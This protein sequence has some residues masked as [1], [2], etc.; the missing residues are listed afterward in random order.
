MRKHNSIAI[1]FLTIPTTFIGTIIVSYS[2]IGNWQEL[3]VIISNE[4]YFGRGALTALVGLVLSVFVWRRGAS[5]TAQQK[6]V[7]F[8]TSLLLCLVNWGLLFMLPS[9]FAAFCAGLWLRKC[10][11]P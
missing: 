11:Q 3:F 5:M 8:S 9:V 2:F 4:S 7:V 6:V 10:S 1:V